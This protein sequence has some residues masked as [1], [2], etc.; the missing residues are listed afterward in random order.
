MTNYNFD[1]A[2]MA[3]ESKKPLSSLKATFIAAP[4]E[5]SVARFTELLKTY[6]PKGNIVLGI[7][8]EPFVEG[9]EGQSQFKMLGVKTVQAVI[10]KVNKASANKIYTLSYLQRELPHII[11]KV[12]FSRAVFVNGSWRQSFHTSP[13]YYVLIN[14]NM[15]YELVSPFT[16]E[17]EALD[18]EAA[19]NALIKRP[20]LEGTFDAEAIMR[21]GDEVAK[22]S[23]DYTFQ[24][25]T[26]LAKK[27][28]NSYKPLLSAFNKV[29]PFQTYAMLNGASREKN[30]SPPNDLNH[31]DTIHAEMMLI[32]EAQKQNIS[33]K[34]TTL[35]VNLMPCPNCARTI[36]ET[37]IAEIIYR[38]DHSEGY[39]VKLLEKVGKAIK[40]IVY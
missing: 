28:K 23:Y 25:G 15:G 11:E 19:T 16:N 35:F 4:R 13:T 30:F 12:N 7:S 1:W 20:Q 31:Y 34:G 3:F 40:R 39:A 22:Q 38:I 9:F 29:V 14:K 24:T 8:K 18:Y 32:V 17:S 27:T 2:E 26:V 37:D 6:L 21:L 33:L 10:D 36:A 5:L